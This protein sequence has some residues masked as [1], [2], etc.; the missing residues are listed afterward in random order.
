MK[1]RLLSILLLCAV[2]SLAAVACTSGDGGDG[3]AADGGG[4]GTAGDMT[5]EQVVAAALDSTY[6]L[7]SYRFD[8]SMDMTMSGDTPAVMLMETVGA[9]DE[10]DEE[11]YMVMDI[12]MSDPEPAEMSTEIYVVDDWLYMG[13]EIT[14]LGEM[15]MKSQMT[16][17]LWNQQMVADQQFGFMEGFIE[18]YVD[19]E[20]LGTETVSGVPC[21]KLS[22]SPDL[23]KLWDWASDQEDMEGVD[24]GFDLE[25]MIE[26]F[27]IT[28]WIAQDSYY[29]VKASLDMAMTIDS[30]Y[31]DMAMTIYIYDI[32]ELVS[33]NLP[34]EAADA[35][36]T[37][38]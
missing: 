4:G 16:E 7:D 36:E 11:M 2:L 21:Y 34:P 22:V 23:A 25:E 15:W 38:L 3:S 24:P 26:D 1:A 9:V 17:E 31:V 10:L 27:H 14:G 33:I 28:E 12:S 29:M 5:A 19:V 8:M 37:T 18:D 30:E 20:M 32:N 35:I 13:M 6:E